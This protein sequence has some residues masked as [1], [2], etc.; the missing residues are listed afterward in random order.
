[1]TERVGVYWFS[2]DLRV[3]D[4]QLLLSASTQVDHL[5]CVFTMPTVSPYLKRYSQSESF[6]EYKLTFLHQALLDLTKSLAQRDQ[7]LY[8]TALSIAE[9]LDIIESKYGL[10]DLFVSASA[11]IDERKTLSSIQ[12][13]HPL[14]TIH[15]DYVSSLFYPNQLP[16]D[17]QQLPDSFS[18]F[19]K[20]VETLPIDEP[21]LACRFL[22]PSLPVELKHI[23][24]AS[25]NT[26]NS[27]A[28]TVQNIN[29]FV[30]GEH[31]GQ[32]H[33]RQ[34]FAGSFA[35]HYKQT[36]NAIDGENYSTQFSPWLALGCVSPKWI[37]RELKQYETVNGAND[38]TYWIYFELLWREY[39][40]WY[41]M[42]FGPQLFRFKGIKPNPPH[43]SLYP[44]RLKMWQLGNTPYPLVNAL[45]HQ[46]VATGYMSNRGRQIV[47]SCLVNELQLDWRYGA[48]FFEV[49]LID[50]DV[51]SNW[52][53]WQYIAGVG[54]DPQPSRHFDLNKQTEQFDPQRMFI[55]KW[56]GDAT[57]MS[58]NSVDITD[59]PIDSM[60]TENEYGKTY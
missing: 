16:F 43:T 1:M 22:P 41:A 59:W 11:G 5:V 54:A 14:L 4:N 29:G 34:Y 17:C 33:C 27:D 24:I 60:E 46:L 51:G 10:H 57:T 42:K 21:A 32:A 39:F 26:I 35:S 38:S 44:Q 12:A 9:I 58:L 31:T 52:G 3:E 2:N 23:D 47:A 7:Q 50:Y 53:N 49:H 55:S 20:R 40:F 18:K 28:D 6:G 25:L 30:G 15:S 37:L 8:C 48:A 56:H 19:R 13:Q 36:R 45:M